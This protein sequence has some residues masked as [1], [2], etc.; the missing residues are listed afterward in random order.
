ML[1]PI[2]IHDNSDEN[3]L[4]QVR[5]ILERQAQTIHKKLPDLPYS[6]I[7]NNIFLASK[8][9]E[10]NT[11][12]TLEKLTQNQTPLFQL[13]HLKLIFTLFTERIQCQLKE[14][15]QQ[16]AL[17]QIQDYFCKQFDDLCRNLE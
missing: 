3:I 4:P 10:Q 2:N 8:D 5:L 9:W 17:D 7:Q 12:L 13:V 6:F 14:Q 16:Q 15:S 1:T 11:G